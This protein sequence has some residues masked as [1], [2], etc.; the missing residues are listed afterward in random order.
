MLVLNLLGCFFY[1]QRR[2][3]LVVYSTDSGL[4]R[5]LRNLPGVDLAHVSRLNLLQLAPGGHLG[6]FVI[7]TE[8]AFS[9]LDAIYGTQTTVSVRC[10]F[11]FDSSCD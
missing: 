9:Q 10:R 4:T 3:P 7:F 8:G 6:R 5:A 1:S 2:G 11:G